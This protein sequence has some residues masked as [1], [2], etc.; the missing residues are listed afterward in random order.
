MSNI[1]R[2]KVRGTLP[3]NFYEDH[4][5]AIKVAQIVSPSVGLTL[6]FGRHATMERNQH[7]GQ[8]AMYEFTIVGEEALAFG[9]MRSLEASIT[10]VG[11]V[12]RESV[13][14]DL[15]AGV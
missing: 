2:V 1:K 9:W 8:T 14:H 11:G 10:R 15:E 4:E 5:L 6:T 7:G 13:C 3:F 12:I